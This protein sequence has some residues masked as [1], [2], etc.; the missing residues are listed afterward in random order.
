MS[1]INFFEKYKRF[2]GESDDEFIV[3]VSKDKDQIGT[4]TDMAELFN[5]ILGYNYGESFYR[6][7]NKKYCKSSGT[8]QY[9]KSNFDQTESEKTMAEK[10]K[11]S[12][13]RFSFVMKEMHGRNRIILMPELKKSLIN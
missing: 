5:A 1:I 8:L 12:E 9:T 13:K 10:E 6:K 7:R 3:R 4:W 11:S 2:D